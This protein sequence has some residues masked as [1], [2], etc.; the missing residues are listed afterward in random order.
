M[1][2]CHQLDRGM[3]NGKKTAF[4]R[5]KSHKKLLPVGHHKTTG[6]RATARHNVILHG[7]NTVIISSGKKF[8]TTNSI[9]KS[10]GCQKT[11]IARITGNV[12]WHDENRLGQVRVNPFTAVCI[13]ATLN[14]EI[15]QT[16]VAHVNWHNRGMHSR[17]HVRTKSQLR[18]LFP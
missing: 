13:R 17:L 1:R 8:L 12:F 2:T 11:A 18:L 3:F 14:L 6:G 7:R 10:T 9:G 15:G 16:K 5:K 4:F